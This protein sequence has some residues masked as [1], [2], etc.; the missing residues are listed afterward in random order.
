MLCCG[1]ARQA[2]SQFQVPPWQVDTQ[3]SSALCQ[4]FKGMKNDVQQV[5]IKVIDQTDALQRA[6]FAKVIPLRPTG[7]LSV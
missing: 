3:V 4:V 6:E 5:A 2:S 1:V 7:L